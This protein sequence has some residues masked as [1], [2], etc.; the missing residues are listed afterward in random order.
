MTFFNVKNQKDNQEANQ[1]SGPFSSL[2]QHLNNYSILGRMSG[3][4]GEGKFH[5]KIQ[6]IIF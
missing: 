2:L 5:L 1:G 4:V 6:T 3:N